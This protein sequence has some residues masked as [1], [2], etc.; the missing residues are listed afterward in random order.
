[1]YTLA[2]QLVC[3]VA[4][5]NSVCVSVCVCVCVCVYVCVC[6]CV[7]VHV[8]VWACMGM[9]VCVCVYYVTACVE[10]CIFMFT[11]VTI[12]LVSRNALDDVFTVFHCHFV[13]CIHFCFSKD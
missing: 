9:Y 8:C 7:S 2:S 11:F 1:M 6:V 13:D 12:S 10:F 5:I 3:L 4:I